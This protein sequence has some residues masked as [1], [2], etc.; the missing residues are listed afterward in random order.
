MAETIQ[1]TAAGNAMPL[2]AALRPGGALLA[3]DLGTTTGWALLTDPRF[4]LEPDLYRLSGGGGGKRLFHQACE[5]FLN[6]CCAASSV[7][8]WRADVAPGDRVG[9]DVEVLVAQG[10]EAGEHRVDLDLLGDV[11]VE[12]GA[13]HVGLRCW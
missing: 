7:C 5:V 13:A 1:T 6:A 12:R 9:R 10:L 4:V 3:L 11:G 2:S 8:G